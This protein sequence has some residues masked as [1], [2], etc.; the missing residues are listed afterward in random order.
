MEEVYGNYVVTYEILND[1]IVEESYLDV[2]LKDIY[3]VKNEVI[4]TERILDSAI[5]PKQFELFHS[6]LSDTLV[7]L[8]EAC[9]LLIDISI[10][11]RYGPDDYQQLLLVSQNKNTRFQIA[12]EQLEKS[13]EDSKMKFE[14][15][16][17]GFRYYY[18]TDNFNQ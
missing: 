16:G 9:D 7:Y 6:V 4:N 5:V 14:R 15:T 8:H 1:L 18:F 17:N 2:P 3:A 11:N 12:T 10:N 13:F